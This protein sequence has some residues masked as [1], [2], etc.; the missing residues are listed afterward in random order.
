VVCHLQQIEGKQLGD[1]A[2]GAGTIPDAVDSPE[3]PLHLL[4]GS[5]A[6]DRARTKLRQLGEQFDRWESVTLGTDF[7]KGE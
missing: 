5:D 1:P 2:R 6:L 3:P 4:L 7:A